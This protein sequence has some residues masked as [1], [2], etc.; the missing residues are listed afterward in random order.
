MSKNTQRKLTGIL[1]SDVAG[2]PLV[3]AFI[4]SIFISFNGFAM[5]WNTSTQLSEIS[6][7]NTE[8]TGPEIEQLFVDIQEIDYP[9]DGTGSGG[10]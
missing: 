3:F 4:V 8:L 2:Y 10:D 7:K 6:D 9:D 1:A 5:E